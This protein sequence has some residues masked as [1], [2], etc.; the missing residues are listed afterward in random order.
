[1]TAPSPEEEKPTP[2]PKTP[3]QKPNADDVF[4]YLRT[5]IR[6]T[7][8]YALL[9]L[10]ILLIYFHPIIGGLLVGIVAG[11]YFGNEIIA[12]IRGWKDF[13]ETE[14]IPRS[15][16]VA[17]VAFAFFLSAPAIFLG[18]ALSLLIKQLFQPV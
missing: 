5:N 13:I 1:M 9:I 6:E 14:G 17:G 12:A 15:L 7:V 3:E 2:P 16:V 10:G 4:Q 8:A 11:I 18:I